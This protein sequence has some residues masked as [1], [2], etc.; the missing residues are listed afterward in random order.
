MQAA[1][2]G[3][4]EE[5]EDFEGFWVR[6]EDVS[7]WLTWEDDRRIAG[8]VIDAYV[9]CKGGETHMISR[10][11][12]DSGRCIFASECVMVQWYLRVS[13]VP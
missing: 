10:L 12:V 13:L 9:G 1:G 4:L 8:Y 11:L 5:E 7:Q 2:K 3:R 6:F